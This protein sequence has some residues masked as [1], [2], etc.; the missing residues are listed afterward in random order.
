MSWTYWAAPIIDSEQPQTVA[1][2]LLDKLNEL[3]PKQ[4]LTVKIAISDN[5][6]DPAKGAIFYYDG[7]FAQ[8]EGYRALQK[9]IC[10]AV[11]GTLSAEKY[12][13]QCQKVVDTLN[14]LTFDQAYF[15]K[16]AGSDASH[17]G[18]NRMVIW[19]SKSED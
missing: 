11:S 19:P 2:T 6:G 14:K 8:P 17:G 5:G 3:P 16:V 4:T 15:A 7:D 18:L 9:G 12:H 1:K 13:A 10:Y